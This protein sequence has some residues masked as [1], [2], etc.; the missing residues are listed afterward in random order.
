MKPLI[1]IDGSA[2]GTLEEFFAHFAERAV[3]APQVKN[4]DAF[5]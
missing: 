2:F 4:L 5:K 1:E 3:T